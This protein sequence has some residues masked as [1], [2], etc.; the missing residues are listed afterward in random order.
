MIREE[1][2]RSPNNSRGAWSLPKYQ[3]YKT[4]PSLGSYLDYHQPN[5]KTRDMITI[6]PSH[7]SLNES[8][9]NRNDDVNKSIFS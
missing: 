4:K 2:H 8:N 1:V 9:I 3:S 5:Q 6:S 7:E